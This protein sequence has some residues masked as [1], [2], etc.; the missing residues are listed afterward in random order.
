MP[1]HANPGGLSLIIIPLG[2]Y[3]VRKKVENGENSKALGQL[4]LFAY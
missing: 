4:S 3:Y 1:A 2:T